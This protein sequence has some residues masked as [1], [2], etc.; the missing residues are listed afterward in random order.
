LAQFDGLLTKPQI[1]LYTSPGLLGVNLMASSGFFFGGVPLEHQEQDI[2]VPIYNL[3]VLVG[4]ITY[5]HNQDGT[6]NVTISDVD[7]PQGNILT[8]KAKLDIASRV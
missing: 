2:Q 3:E 8:Q 1:A 5:I 4:F 7:N 6:V